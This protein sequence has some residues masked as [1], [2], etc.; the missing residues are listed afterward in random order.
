LNLEPGQLPERSL[1][2]FPTSF[3]GVRE[4]DAERVLAVNGEKAAASRQSTG[5]EV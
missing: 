5:F 2:T 3:E 4:V 1:S